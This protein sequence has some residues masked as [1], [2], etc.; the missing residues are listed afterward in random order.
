MPENETGYLVCRKGRVLLKQKEAQGSNP[1]LTVSNGNLKYFAKVDIDMHCF[2]GKPE[3][4]VHT[5]NVSPAPSKQDLETAK[6]LGVKVC[7]DFH[8]K[9]KC[10]KAKG[11]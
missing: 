6:T 3:A 4:L 9:I 1:E 2:R 10:Y 7:V 5:H 8:G 11:G